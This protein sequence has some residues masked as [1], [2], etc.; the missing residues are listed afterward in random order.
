MNQL[1][2]DLRDRGM[3][4][5]LEAERD[6]W[7]NE[8][9][10]QLARYAAFHSIFKTED[11][12]EACERAGVENPHD[13]HVWGALTNLASRRGLIQ[14]TGQYVPSESPKTHGH[15]VKLWERA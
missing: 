7:I 15:P 9:L 1:G 13:H 2:L 11:F 12:R 4:R 8:A 6:E 5:T 14:W 10:G 3:A